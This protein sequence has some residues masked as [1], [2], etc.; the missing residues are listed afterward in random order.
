MLQHRIQLQSQLFVVRSLL[1]TH[2][3]LPLVLLL[4]NR[5]INL[6]NFDSAWFLQLFLIDSDLRQLGYLAYHFLCCSRDF[7]R[8]F[9]L[10]IVSSQFLLFESISRY[11][12]CILI[13]RSELLCIDFAVLSLSEVLVG[14]E[15]SASV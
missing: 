5:L 10:F 8:P 3:F 13:H 9:D 12:P 15:K 4:P 6:A 7:Q 2:H 11:T 1:K 14:A